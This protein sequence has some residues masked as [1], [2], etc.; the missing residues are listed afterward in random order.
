MESVPVLVIVPPVRP[1]PVAT[2]VTVPPDEETRH[3]PFTMMQPP[4]NWMPLA[5]VEVAEA[6]ETFRYVAWTPAANVEV[7]VVEVEMR[8][9]MVSEGVPVACSCEPLYESKVPFTILV[10]SRPR[11]PEE[12]TEPVRPL[13]PATDVTVPVFEVRQT[14]PTETQPPVNWMPL[15]KVEEAEVEVTFRALAWRPQPKVEEAVVEVAIR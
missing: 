13:F 7:A 15:A 10:K 11:F 14:P 8:Y 2:E 3:A 5:K 1:L 4:V 6:P 9:P 12:V